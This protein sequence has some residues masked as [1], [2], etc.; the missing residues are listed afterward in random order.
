MKHQSPSTLGAIAFRFADVHA[1]K[2]GSATSS[3]IATQ[4]AGANHEDGSGVSV[5][6]PER[7]AANTL[8][9]N[10]SSPIR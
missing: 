10:I 3:A 6:L 2:S 1:P 9:T 8:T 5:I 4:D 7:L